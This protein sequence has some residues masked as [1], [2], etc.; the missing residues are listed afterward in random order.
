ML[1]EADCAILAFRLEG[2]KVYYLNFSHLKLYLTEKAMI[3]NDREGNHWKLY[4][5]SDYIQVIQN[6]RH[7]Q[8][9]PDNLEVL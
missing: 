5:W 6:T 1:K 8:I 2:D 9:R 7:F 3:N 4:I